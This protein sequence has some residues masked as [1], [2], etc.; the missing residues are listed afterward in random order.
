MLQLKWISTKQYVFLPATSPSSL[1]YFFL[2][3]KE[4]MEKNINIKMKKKLII[5]KTEEKKKKLFFQRSQLY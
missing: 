5:K 1:S 4:K 2:K 3:Y